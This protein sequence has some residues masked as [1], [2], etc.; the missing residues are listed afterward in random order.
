MRIAA[1]RADAAT[2]LLRAFRLSAA[3]H[4]VTIERAAIADR[5][6][7]SATFEGVRH[8]VR[9]DLDGERARSWLALLPEAELPMRG[10]I[11]ADLAIDRVADRAGGASADL[12][13]LTI[14]E[15]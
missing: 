11:V 9:L 1:T 15:Q 4:G 3:S 2:L 13:V 5:P 7:A 8:T 14:S 10:H 6:W 12:A